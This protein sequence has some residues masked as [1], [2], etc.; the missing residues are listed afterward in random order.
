MKFSFFPS[1]VASYAL[2]RYSQHPHQSMTS[3]LANSRFIDLNNIL[4]EFYLRFGTVTG[5]GEWLDKHDYNQAFED[6]KEDWM[7]Q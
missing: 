1:A 7:L 5:A 6:S 2:E 4:T 3:Q